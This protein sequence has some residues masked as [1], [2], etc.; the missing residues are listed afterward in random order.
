MDIQRNPLL[1]FLSFTMHDPKFTL[2][3]GG[4]NCVIN[5][6]NSNLEFVLSHFE[7]LNSEAKF[8]KITK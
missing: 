7:I 3:D 5:I 4:K 8:K 6:R 2:I 1:R